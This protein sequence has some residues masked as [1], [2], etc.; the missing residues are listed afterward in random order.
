MKPARRALV[1]S[2]TPSHP[3]DHGH[4]NRVRQTTSLL[5]GAGCAIDFLLYPM[6]GDW[7]K[8]IPPGLAQM[9]AAWG[10]RR[11][12][13]VILAPPTRALHAPPA[14]RDHTID[15]WWDP[16]LDAHLAFLCE[17]RAYDVMLVNYVFLS[18]AFRHAPPQCRRVLDTHDRLAGRRELF[19]RHGATPEFFHTTEAE[20]ARG[21][22]R[23]DLVLAIKPGEAEAFAAAGPKVITLPFFAHGA[24]RRRAERGPGRPGPL[25]VG[26]IGADNSVNAVNLAAFIRRLD[27]WRALFLPDLVVI[28]AGDVCRRVAP[29]PG[30]VTLLGRVEKADSF[31]DAIDVVVA[32][33]AFST[34]LKIKVAE[35]LAR[36]MPLVATADAFDGFASA[37]PLHVLPDIEAVCGALVALAADRERLAALA[38]AS[39]QAA[40]AARV[41]R[42]IGAARFCAALNE[43]PPARRVA[44][45]EAATPPPRLIFDPA[46]PLPRRL[47][48]ESAPPPLSW[49][50]RGGGGI[51][52]SGDLPRATPFGILLIE[53]S[54]DPA[55]SEAGAALLAACL[56]ACAGRRLA[57]L[58][59]SDLRRDQS[60]LDALGLLP[61]PH[62]MI[63][64]ALGAE[65]RAVAARLARR[66]EAAFFALGDPYPLALEPDAPATIRD[67]SEH[68]LAVA[69]WLR[70]PPARPA[71]VVAPGAIG[72]RGREA[73]ALAAL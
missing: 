51:G 32:P 22:A 46:A 41:A 8:E 65:S 54:E 27:A 66:A 56:A 24:K 61:A 23:A 42:A 69:A 43:K 33:L 48:R 34:G 10:G 29:V 57:I 49:A 59:V 45:D 21:L 60:A 71:P 7:G 18:R 55:K 38:A 15:E 9:Q 20:E 5:A 17:R 35:A 26:F 44:S 6:D 14:G 52:G 50:R 64:I 72:A 11:G 47:A 28:V 68:V 4:R 16:S 25:R 1:V 30:F 13:T 58:R 12:G 63:G 37:D 2:P 40:A 53:A 70:A 62:A 3:S 39:G 67:L 19:E 73:T 31:Y 36:G